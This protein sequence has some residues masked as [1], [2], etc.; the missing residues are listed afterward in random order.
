MVTA[1]VASHHFVRLFPLFLSIVIIT[2]SCNYFSNVYIFVYRNP[3]ILDHDELFSI[4][5]GVSTSTFQLPAAQPFDAN[6]FASPLTAEPRQEAA[7][8]A[9]S[10]LT[11]SSSDTSAGIDAIP[12]LSD[13]GA[14]N[15]ASTAHMHAEQ[16]VSDSSEARSN[17][18]ELERPHHL[19]SQ[20][21]SLI[22]LAAGP[23]SNAMLPCPPLC[24]VSFAANGRVLFFCNSRISLVIGANPVNSTSRVDGSAI[25]S[26]APS[27]VSDSHQY[28]LTRAKV[29]IQDARCSL[30][31]SYAQLLG[32]L[33]QAAER[34]EEARQ[35][36]L[37]T[38]AFSADASSDP[39]GSASEAI[40]T[41]PSSPLDAGDIDVIPVTAAKGPDLVPVLES[42][43]MAPSTGADS[44]NDSRSF[45]ESYFFDPPD[46]ETH[47]TYCAFIFLIDAIYSFVYWLVVHFGFPS[48]LCHSDFYA[49]IR[50]FDW[51]RPRDDRA[52]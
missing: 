15:A 52:V 40:P 12:L 36:R 7:P 32:S 25:L 13:S 22:K 39:N 5:Q 9:E 28:E 20:F 42:F 31:R 16:I 23:T 34:E 41:L 33:K 6:Y 48:T 38:S 4:C 27:A 26:H 29:A 45:F 24:G 1:P 30:P 2:L 8:S 17:S 19:D 49:M 18:F 21:P 44:I 14:A 43:S 50:I 11:T 51:S 35:N 46:S 3:T 10:T 47:G 37:S